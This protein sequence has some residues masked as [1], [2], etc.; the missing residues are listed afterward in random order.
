MMLFGPTSLYSHRF[1]SIPI[2]IW[3]GLSLASRSRTQ[4]NVGNEKTEVG[5]NLSSRTKSKW[6]EGAR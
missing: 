3:E 5:M 4:G 6:V 2:C 1:V